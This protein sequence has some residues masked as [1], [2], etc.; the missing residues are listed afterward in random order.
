MNT[1]H[2]HQE[3]KKLFLAACELDDDRREAFLDQAC[4]D[5]PELRRELESLLRHHFPTTI[6]GE[7]PEDATARKV[8]GPVPPVPPLPSI[9]EAPAD[10]PYRP[11]TAEPPPDRL[12]DP[13]RDARPGPPAARACPPPAATCRP[14]PC[15]Y[16]TAP[17]AYV[18]AAR[19]DAPSTEGDH[20]PCFAPP[21]G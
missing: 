19:P 17:R 3:V 9:G 1:Q 2:R 5:D 16:L 4:A 6:F 21:P 13:A 18:T 8:L 15:A 14:P 12:P 20:R 10:S 7:S 11:G